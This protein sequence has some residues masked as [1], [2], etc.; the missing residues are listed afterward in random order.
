M[1]EIKKSDPISWS[2]GLFIEDISHPEML[3]GII[4]R[5]AV[6]RGILI[7]V[8][9]PPLPPG[10]ICITASQIPG[11]NRVTIFSRSMPLLAERDIGFR[12]QPLA[13][14][15]GPNISVLLDLAEQFAFT[16]E[17]KPPL[18]PFP[19]SEE[20]QK[21][22]DFYFS[23]GSPEE[24]L[25]E[26]F[27]ILEDTYHISRD[28]PAMEHSVFGAYAMPEAASIRII[29]SSPWIY[30]L[31]K[32]AAGAL[33]K[34][35]KS[36]RVTV[37]E[38]GTPLEGRT[39]QSS[40]I[41]TYAALL[42]NKSGKPV[43]IL[44][45]KAEEFLGA[46]PRPPV[47]IKHRTG[48]DTEGRIKSTLVNINLDTGAFPI[49]AEEHISVLSQTMESLYGG[50]SYSLSAAA[51][52]T[53]APPPD[54]ITGNGPSEAFFALETHVSRIAELSQTDPITWRKENLYRSTGT[55]DKNPLRQERTRVIP[56]LERIAAESDFYRK[57]A[58][59]ESI[60]KRRRVDSITE[61]SLRGIGAALSFQTTNLFQKEKKEKP[62]SI[63]LRLE[64]GERLFI[65]ASS[66]I[67]SRGTGDLW[68]KIA[69]EILGID[70]ETVILVKP[71]TEQVPD[72]GPTLFSRNITITTELVRKACEGIKK[73]RFRKPLPIE[74][75]KTFRFPRGI[76]TAGDLTIAGS[77][78]RSWGITVADVEVDPVTYIPVIKG[79]W[80]EIDAGHVLD[81]EYAKK[82]TETEVYKTLSWVLKGKNPFEN[83]NETAVI[84]ETEA[85]IPLYIGFSENR[86]GALP[87]GI[88]ELP[89]NTIP[90]AVVAALSQ[91]TG[92]Y[93]DTIPISPS[94]I[95]AYMRNR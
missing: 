64:Q 23:E 76:Q 19:A 39:W 6:D 5:S 21:A 44:L 22:L 42:C 16:I 49:M 65:F 57:Y 89:K 26:S 54:P 43:R 66:V 83:T 75:I 56:L 59:F 82:R 15:A 46:C 36:I 8:S 62:Y 47:L 24:S 77:L 55:T 38:T 61:R 88:G 4:I 25:K 11:E 32:T 60:R 9:V 74:V 72:S 37:P 10:Y 17:K 33:S 27:Q 68:K 40:I 52:S 73:S 2:G 79:V 70:E 78:S 3:K 67:C 90:S 85:I 7:S 35:E 94:L 91:A 53:S 34:P 48:L 86:K 84:R 29:A 92:N 1:A 63:K 93:Y 45:S 80:M 58:A 69:A 81:K 71:D 31:R 28:I 50:D 30:H 18:P 14:L 51:F 95:S 87:A 12:G 13:L 41:G 20:Q